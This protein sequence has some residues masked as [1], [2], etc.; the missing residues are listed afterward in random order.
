MTVPCVKWDPLGAERHKTDPPSSRQNYPGILVLQKRVKIAICTKHKPAQEVI[1]FFNNTAN[2]RNYMGKR[3]TDLIEPRCLIIRSANKKNHFKLVHKASRVNYQHMLFFDSD[4]ANSD[5][6]SQGVTFFK[7]GSLGLDIETFRNG[8]KWYHLNA[9]GNSDDDSC[10]IGS[11]D[12]IPG[13]SSDRS[14]DGS[15]ESGNG[16]THTAGDDDAGL[17]F[18]QP[19]FPVCGN[20]R[21]GQTFICAADYNRKVQPLAYPGFRCSNF[22]IEGGAHDMG[23]F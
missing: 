10:S 13:S 5:V 17:E 2:Y 14:A 1:H 20:L 11:D 19:D 9:S 3:L 22:R 6:E 12:E 7:V 18:V 21:C 23:I 8:L 4:S 16:P 15:G